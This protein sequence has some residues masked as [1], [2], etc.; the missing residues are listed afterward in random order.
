MESLE[1]VIEYWNRIE[2][3][4]NQLPAIG[5]SVS[6]IEKNQALLRSLSDSFS[7]AA[8]AI[9]STGEKYDQAI[10]HLVVGESVMEKPPV[11]R[12]MVTSAYNSK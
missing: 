1:Y 12:A 2:T 3:L 11:Q 6:E 7:V 4:V 5:H 10:V 8:Q 9:R